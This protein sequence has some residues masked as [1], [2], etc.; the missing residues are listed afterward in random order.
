MIL[1]NRL[2]RWGLGSLFIGAG[3]YYWADGAWPALVFGTL[4]VI[5]GFFRPRR[6][7]DNSCSV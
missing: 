6:C 4:M 1:F 2:L 7:V 3:V 5:T